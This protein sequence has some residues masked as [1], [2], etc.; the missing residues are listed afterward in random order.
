M[1]GLACAAAAASLLA[2]L[3]LAGAADAQG[4]NPPGVQRALGI[5]PALG[6]VTDVSG[7]GNLS[8]HGGPTMT[9]N[10]VYAIFWIPSGY[11]VSS[12][13][14]SLIDRFFTDVAVDSGR[15]TNVYY[16]DTQYYQGSG[17]RTYI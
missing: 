17:T 9:T 13:Y 11:S 3:L 2:V 15:T 10:K 6:K 4:P 7:Y 16:S 5:V 8:Y 1:R 12:L 14:R